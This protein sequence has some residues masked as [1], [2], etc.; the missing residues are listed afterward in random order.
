VASL[1]LYSPL[2]RESSVSEFQMRQLP[3]GAAVEL[4]GDNPDLPRIVRKLKAALTDA[5]LTDPEVTVKEVEW[6]PRLEIS[7][8]RTRFVPLPRENAG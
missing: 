6:L 8:K 2:N 7:G 5:G 3:N 1:K 4:R